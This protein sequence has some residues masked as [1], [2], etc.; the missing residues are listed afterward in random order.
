MTQTE[1]HGTLLAG[2][3]EKF[4]LKG[5][6]H[7]EP[8]GQGLIHKTWKVQ[9]GEGAY[10]LQQVN[11]HV[12]TQPQLIAEN[13]EAIG[14]YLSESSPD[15][16]FVSPL[17]DPFGKTLLQ[18]A[19]GFFRIFPF[20]AGSHAF[21]RVHTATQAR[22]AAQQFGRFTRVLAGMDVSELKITIPRFH[23]LEYRVQQFTYSLNSAMPQRLEAAAG[24]IE[25][26]N[27]FSWVVE[28]F[29]AIKRNK[30]FRLRVTH[31]DTKISNVLFNEKNEA[32]C[33]IDLDTVMPG[34]FISDL[35]DMMRTYLCE[36]TEEEQDLQQISVRP[37]IYHA[38]V[39]GYLGEMEELLTRE[40]AEAVPFAGSFMIYMQ[41]LRFLTDYLNNDVY[42]G[43]RYP[44]QNLN[45]AANQFT[46]LEKYNALAAV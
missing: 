10:V 46:L 18:T 27:A 22:Q 12:F 4:G 40:E 2:I 11:H 34:Y 29:I 43:S 35:G 36:A 7:F 15:Y 41:A 13:V 5:S 6:F 8:I 37:E 21:D 28:K 17:K 33:V 1:I 9:T 31:H 19:E 45:R 42:Y 39:E 38:I 32:I 24:W 16:F 44:G 25:R 23:D 20:V 3:T 26:A 30:N 14:T